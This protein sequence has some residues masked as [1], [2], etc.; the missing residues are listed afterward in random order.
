MTP[1]LT[2]IT[3]SYNQ[4]GFLQRTLDSVLDQ[5]YSDLEYI[6]VDGGSTDGS[7]DILHR[8]DDRLAW[9]V[10]EPDQGQ[11]NALNKG[12][13]RATGDLVAYINSDDYYLPGAFEAAVS[14]LER[15]DALWM[16]GASR[17]VDADGKP[18]EVWRPQPLPAGRIWW[19]LG[20]WGV[21]QPSTFWRRE[22]FERHGYF[23]EDMH[24]VFDTEYGL[25]L[26]F[27][28]ELPVA[29]DQELAVR[30]VHPEAKSWNPEEFTREK[31]RFRSLFRPVL[32]RRERVALRVAPLIDAT[33]LPRLLRR[34]GVLPPVPATAEPLT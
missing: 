18:T 11:T 10:S 27:A 7:A 30:V 17:F 9:W 16:V 28:G 33:G 26:A 15:S 6:V 22:A 24:Y 1:R 2:I 23:R 21:P 3:P 5:G 19:I 13:R 34:L 14:A 32:T 25:R 29:I 8:Y 20:P 4:A 12:L 31:R